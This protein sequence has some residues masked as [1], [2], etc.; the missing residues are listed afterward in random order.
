MLEIDVDVGRLV[1]VV[2]EEA[3]EQQFVLD[4][5]DRGDAEHVADHRIGGRAPALAEDLLAAGELDDRIDGEEIGRVAPVG[6][7]PQLMLEQLAHSACGGAVRE[8]GRERGPGQPLQRLLRRA[9]ASSR[10]RRD[11]GSSSS[12]KREGAALGDVGAWR[13]SRRERR[14]SAAPSPP[15]SSDGGR[16]SAR[17]GSRARRSCMLADRGDD[18]LEHALVGAVVEDVAG[19]EAAQA[20]PAGQRVERVEPLRLARAAAMGEREMGARRRKY[21]PSGR[22]RS[23]RPRRPRRAPEPRPAR[24]TRRRHPPSGG[25]IGPSRPSC[26]R[27]GSCRR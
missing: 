3:L 8:F 9:A 23:R 25:S 4:R 16:R 15:G 2:G 21:P 17:G 14:R 22:A 1:A 20:V 26:G 18:V 12:R 19:G 13:G 6:D 7:Q 10:S 11:I 27:R 24:P 5:I